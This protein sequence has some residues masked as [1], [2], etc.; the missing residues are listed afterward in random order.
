M[1]KVHARLDPVTLEVIR[2]AL[3]AISNEMSADL[4]RASYNMMVYEVRDYCCALIDKRGRLMSQNIGGVSHFVAD[5]GVI[6]QDAMKRYGENGFQPGDVLITNH[7]AVAGQHLNNVVIYTPVFYEN[8]LI[9]FAMVRAHWM[10]V[11]GLSTGFGGSVRITDPWMEGLQL[12]QLK[13]VEAGKTNEVLM[14]VIRDNIRFPESSFGDMRAQIA[15]C[16]LAERRIRELL[17]KYGKERVEQYIEAVYDM[18]DQK[19]R[20][21]VSEI[22]DGEYEAE[23]WMDDDGFTPDDP[24]RIH[25][26]VIVKGDSMTIDLSGCSG[27]R[28]GA[29]NSRTMAA[30][31]VAFKALTAPLDPVNDGSFRALNVIIPEGNVMMASYPAPMSKWSIILPTVIDTILKALAPALPDRIPA[32]H[33]GYLGGSI[34]CFGT[35]PRTQK[36]FVLQSI[37]G[38]GWGGRPHEDGESASV[39]V[40]QGDVRNAPIESLEI[41]APVLIEERRLRTDSGGAGTFRGGLGLDVTI[42]NLSETSWNLSQGRRR[43]CPPWGLWGGREGAVSDYLLKYPD[44][45][46][47]ES[48]DISRH[49]VPRDTL[50]KIRTSGGGGWGSPL[51][52]DPEKVRWDVLEGFVSLQAAREEYGVVFREEDFTIDHEAT[53][54]LR[55]SKTGKKEGTE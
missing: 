42:R 11:G 31:F 10:D 44:K 41:K 51:E 28:K 25:A 37:E 39:S 24:V 47:W 6:V 20:R 18:T 45:E 13:I 48:V 8:E 9:C 4:Q 17:D 30:S 33:M 34:T 5:L 55:E 26:R 16:R 49:T 15:A 27:Q 52:R 12:D 40:C 21:I 1:A 43:T 14:K 22:P 19:C 3:P 35:D 2:N 54:R 50:V 36:P 32:A 29:I 38:G 46:Q 53:R 23:S 7:Q